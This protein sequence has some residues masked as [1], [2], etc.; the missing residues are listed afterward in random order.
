MDATCTDNIAIP[1]TSSTSLSLLEESIRE[2]EVDSSSDD[3]SEDN[4]RELQSVYN[5]IEN[6]KEKRID[7]DTE[8]MIYWKE[9]KYAIPH[10]AK[11]A[12]IVHAVLATQVS[13][14]RAFSA[15]KVMLDDRRCK[16]SAQ[17]LQKLMFVKL[18]AEFTY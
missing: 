16:L 4:S 13:V 14:E 2:M 5:E 12:T 3:E 18:N 1:S 7:I 15:L 10:V 17:N 6:Y 8:L 9:K 11:L